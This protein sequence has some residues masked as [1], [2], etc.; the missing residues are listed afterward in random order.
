MK[1]MGLIST[2]FLLY[3]E[4]LVDDI[5]IYEDAWGFETE[6]HDVISILKQARPVAGK[7]L[8]NRL[9]KRIRVKN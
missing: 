7:K 5:D 2:H 4:I 3:Q 1:P 6:F 8:T 9:I